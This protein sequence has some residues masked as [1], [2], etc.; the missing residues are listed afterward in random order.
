MPCIEALVPNP[1]TIRE[2]ET[3][4]EAL[5]RLEQNCVRIAPVIDSAGRVIGMFG[6]HSLMED[7]LPVAA[8]IKGGLEDLDFIVGG[9]PSAAKKIRKIGPH[10]VKDHMETGDITACFLYPDTEMLETIRT[11]TRRGSPLPVVERK[12]HK[13]IGLV[14]EQSCLTRLHV[15]LQ[16]IEK[17]EAE[18]ATETTEAAEKKTATEKKAGV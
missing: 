13:F 10:M 5:A 4:L 15:V 2:D 16:E 1:V 8:Q 7:L 11:L 6:L 17:E 14:S 9:S 18:E 12:T 3:V